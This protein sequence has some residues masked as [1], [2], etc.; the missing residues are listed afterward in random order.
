METLHDVL[1]A[2][3]GSRSRDRVVHGIKD[4]YDDVRSHALL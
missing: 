1:L 4:I 2:F 3:L